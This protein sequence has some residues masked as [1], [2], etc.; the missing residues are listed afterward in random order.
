[1]LNTIRTLS[2]LVLILT[3]FSCSEKY[4]T[5]A[6]IPGIFA[7]LN[8]NVKSSGEQTVIRVFTAEGQEVTEE[9]LIQVNGEVISGNIFASEAE[10]VYEISAFYLNLEAEKLHVRY[11]DGS[12]IN[13]RKRIL[14]EDY[15]G[16]WCGWCPRVSHGM[17]LLDEVTEDDIVFI[18]IHRAPTG[19]SDPYNYTNAAELEAMINTPGY[20]KGFINRIHQWR[21]P[22]PFNINQVVRFK[23]NENPKL[24]LAVESE[25]VGNKIEFTIKTEFARDFQNLKLVVQLLENGL[26]HPQVNYT[27]FYGG[28]NPIPN[29]VHDYTLRKTFTHILGDEIPASETKEHNLW[30]R[31]FSEDVPDFIENT[32]KLDIVAFIV[33]EDNEVINVRLA[34]VGE[35]QVFEYID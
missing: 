9:S 22:E 5:E 23:Q 34:K 27:D 6:G 8:S 12:E 26:I 13:Y 19:T 7:S 3:F 2:L 30:I 21:F 33:N 11:H 28:Q 10:G 4:E 24:G 32:D 31:A 18:A 14:V 20:P 15:T 35:N 17:K 29:Y 25:L 16:T 1:M